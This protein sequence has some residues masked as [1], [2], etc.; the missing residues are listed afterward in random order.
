MTPTQRSELW[1][2]IDRLD[3]DIEECA[4]SIWSLECAASLDDEDE[5]ELDELRSEEISLRTQRDVLLSRFP[6][7]RYELAAE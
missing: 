2:D 4:E 6:E 3:R 1:C 5:Y 7:I